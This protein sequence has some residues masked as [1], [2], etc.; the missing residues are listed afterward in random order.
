ME[1]IERGDALQQ[2]L[3]GVERVLELVL[4]KPGGPHW[5]SENC[6][7]LV[8]GGQVGV[9]DPDV[10]PQ[11]GDVWWFSASGVPHSGLT[12]VKV[13]AGMVVKVGR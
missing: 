3:M 10:G 1:V 4:D 2:L 13:D 11:R 6:E 12:L 5:C 8:C 9:A 7:P